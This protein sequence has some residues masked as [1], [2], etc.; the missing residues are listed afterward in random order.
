[1]SG[2]KMAKL[3]FEYRARVENLYELWV[4]NARD[5]RKSPDALANA[6]VQMAAHKAKLDEIDAT[7]ASFRSNR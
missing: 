5:E 4:L 3:V 2:K 7:L 6:K 1:M